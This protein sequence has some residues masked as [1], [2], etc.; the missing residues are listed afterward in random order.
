MICDMFL[1]RMNPPTNAHIN[2]IKSMKNPPVIVLVRAIKVV[3]RVRNPFPVEYQ[4]EMLLKVVPNAT[5]VEWKDGYVPDIIQHL[6]EQDIQVAN[7]YA[8]T[9]RCTEYDGM[10]NRANKTLE[11]Q[12]T[13]K[14]IEVKRSHEDISATK[15]R[16]SLRTRDLV[17]FKKMMPKILHEEFEYMSKIVSED[18]EGAAPTNATAGVENKEQPIAKKVVRRKTYAEFKDGK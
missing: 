9:D 11:E 18:G 1:G 7:V 14:I 15:V 6:K 16:E 13:T 8:G 5:I 4:R 2:I 17:G 3:D 10:I 12:I